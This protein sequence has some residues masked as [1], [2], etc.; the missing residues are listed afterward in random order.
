[1]FNTNYQPDQHPACGPG[2]SNP[3][4]CEQFQYVCA[5]SPSGRGRRV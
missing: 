4:A 5:H 2:R 1:V 3:S